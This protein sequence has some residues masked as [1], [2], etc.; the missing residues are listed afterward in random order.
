MLPELAA[1]DD[2]GGGCTQ[3]V[4]H[5]CV[6]STGAYVGQACSDGATG[7]CEDCVKTYLPSYC[8]YKDGPSNSGYKVYESNQ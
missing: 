5:L 8:F 7:G 1:A 3:Q 6:R 4:D 2:E